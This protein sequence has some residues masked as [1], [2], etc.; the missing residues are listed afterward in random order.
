MLSSSCPVSI[1]YRDCEPQSLGTASEAAPERLRIVES[2]LKV[3]REGEAR[4]IWGG[5]GASWFDKW[6]ERVFLTG[7]RRVTLP[8]HE[9]LIFFDDA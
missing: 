6:V 8:L 1:R 9:L 5:I 4:T 3:G 2:G 7:V